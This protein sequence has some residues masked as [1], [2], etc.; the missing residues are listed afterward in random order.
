M[1]DSIRSRLITIFISLTV[2]PLL[3]LGGV[4]I[5]QNYVVQLEQIKESQQRKTILASDNIS[6]FLHEQENKILTFLRMHYF[7]D[8]S[9]EQQRLERSRERV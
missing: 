6:L 8:L 1:L 4:L 3:L 2:V 7:P 9:H 5:W